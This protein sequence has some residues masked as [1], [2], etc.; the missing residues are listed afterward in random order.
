MAQATIASPQAA[1]PSD[2]I[3]DTIDSIIVAFILAFVFR[4]FIVEAFIIPTGSMGPTLYGLHAQIRCSNCAYPFVF[5]IP[6]QQEVSR[7]DLTV[8]CPNCGE[9]DHNRI[10]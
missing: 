9:R 4:A 2:S 1:R 8:T 7:S 3:R 5:N 10:E 6:P